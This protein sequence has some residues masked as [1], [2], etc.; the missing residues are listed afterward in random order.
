M[1]WHFNQP[2]PQCSTSGSRTPTSLS[3]ML[4]SKLLSG[5]LAEVLSKAER[6]LVHV[7]PPTLIPSAATQVA[8]LGTA[9][10]HRFGGS[11]RLIS[12]GQMEPLPRI[13]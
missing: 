13:Q 8:T 2:R 5:Q 11:V 3:G 10:A 9:E 4:S 12:F 1:T 6:V 7:L